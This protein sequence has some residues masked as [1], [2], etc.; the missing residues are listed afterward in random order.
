MRISSLS[1]N[2]LS[3]YSYSFCY[4]E[5]SIVKS[6][7]LLFFYFDGKSNIH[8]N[9]VQDRISTAELNHYN[10]FLP[11]TLWRGGMTLIKRKNHNTYYSL[12]TCIFK[13]SGDLKNMFSIKQIIRIREK[14]IFWKLRFFITYN[15]TIIKAN[16]IFCM[17]YGIVLYIII[18]CCTS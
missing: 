9:H 11:V 7:L 13:H 10:T 1:F 8:L 18:R 12:T 16:M 4:S 14:K 6:E 5:L 3:Y 15:V 17:R 2:L